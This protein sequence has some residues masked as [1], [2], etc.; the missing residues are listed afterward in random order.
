[1]AIFFKRLSADADIK[2]LFSILTLIGDPD[3]KNEEK[4]LL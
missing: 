3:V 1:L 4:V 2:P